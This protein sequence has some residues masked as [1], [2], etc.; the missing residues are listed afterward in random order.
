MN[1]AKRVLV[2]AP[3]PFFA[4]RG[5][6]VRIYEEIV[7]LQELGYEVLLCTYGL[8]RDMPGVE[9]VRTWNFPWYRK[10]DAGPSITKVLLIPLLWFTA[11][12]AARGYSP[13]IVHA[14]LHEGAIIA[15]LMKPFF[16]GAAFFVD[17]QGSLVGELKHH[18]FIPSS[19]ILV[20]LFRGIERI[21][22]SWF[23]ILTQ[24]RMLADQI[25]KLGIEEDH[26]YVVGDGVDPSRFAP[27][28]PAAEIEF[29]PPRLRGQV[30]II[31]MGL[32]TSYQGVDLLMQAFASVKESTS[33]SVKLLIVGYPNIE[34]YAR[35]AKEL[36][37]DEDVTFFGKVDYTKVAGYLSLGDIAVSSKI[38]VAEGDGKLYNYL[39]MGLSV[40][41]FDRPVTRE[42]VGDAGIIVPIGDAEAMVRA[43]VGLLNDPEERK[44]LSKKAR[45]RAEKELSW[46]SVG[47]RIQKVYEQHLTARA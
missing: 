47:Q 11:V 45:E 40:V 36:G 46:K 24:S 34:H 37:I 4:D 25:C 41:A 13:A 6:H 26:V 5:C 15:R 14:H 12:R 7:A 17:I 28:R 20:S 43:I 1:R 19:G 44:R 38:S 35:M 31:Y 23:P 9:T 22:L 32:L 30:A 39:S 3:T 10:L 33:V 42:I 16:S 8:G 29:D 2:I 18:R 21:T 27:G